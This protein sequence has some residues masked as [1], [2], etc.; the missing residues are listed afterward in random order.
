MVRFFWCTSGE[1]GTRLEPL[2][3]PQLAERLREVER[4]DYGKVVFLDRIP[5]DDNGCWNAPDDAVVLIKGEIVVPE[6]E[7]VVTRYK[8]PG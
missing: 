3:S 4:G 2:S 5:E 7:K 1:D 8:V 6:P